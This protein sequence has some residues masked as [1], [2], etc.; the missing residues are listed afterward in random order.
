VR[1]RHEG[2]KRV[3]ARVS[4]SILEDQ[5]NLRFSNIYSHK[6]FASMPGGAKGNVAERRSTWLR[7]SPCNFRTTNISCQQVN[8]NVLR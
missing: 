3:F 2:S 8:A 1:E 4:I 7:G 5:N 6:S